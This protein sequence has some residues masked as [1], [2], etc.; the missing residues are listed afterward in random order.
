MGTGHC[1]HPR[2]SSKQP[3]I[4]FIPEATETSGCCSCKEHKAKLHG[5]PGELKPL[6]SSHLHM[7]I[8]SADLTPDQLNSTSL[9]HCLSFAKFQSLSDSSISLS[10]IS[11]S[12][13]LGWQTSIS[14][15][16]LVSLATG[17]R[18]GYAGIANQTYLSSHS[19]RNVPMLTP[20]GSFPLPVSDHS[21]RAYL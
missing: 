18:Q 4:V 20:L 21:C 7:L 9:T 19:G 15:Y 10:P 1:T 3:I 17:T 2:G 13:G 11:A 6:N 14:F 5:P 8:S 12:T 16:L